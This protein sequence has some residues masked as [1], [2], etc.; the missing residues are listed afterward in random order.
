MDELDEL[1][2]EKTSTATLTPL[3][4]VTENTK[5][6]FEKDI[7]QELNSLG[8]NYTSLTSDNFVLSITSV[9]G[10]AQ[11]LGGYRTAIIKPV[12]D[13]DNT[14]GKITL[15]MLRHN[16]YATDFNVYLVK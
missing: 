12:M 11:S 15:T 3:F 2:E 5:D 10:K 8:V 16:N 9:K 14:T 6:K 13:Y 1:V 4:S 7:I